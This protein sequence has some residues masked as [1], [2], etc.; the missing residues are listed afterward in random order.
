MNVKKQGGSGLEPH[1]SKKNVSKQKLESSFLKYFEDKWDNLFLFHNGFMLNFAADKSVQDY[2]AN[3]KDKK[4]IAQA[5]YN[6]DT[7]QSGDNSNKS[8]FVEEFKKTFKESKNFEIY[9]HS[10]YNREGETNK[11]SFAM[12]PTTTAKTLRSTGNY[13]PKKDLVVKLEPLKKT[14]IELR[15][16]EQIFLENEFNVIDFSKANID[17]KFFAETSIKNLFDNTADP[18]K[19]SQNQH[20]KAYNNLDFAKTYKEIT[21]NLS[22][23]I[24][25]EETYVEKYVTEKGSSWWP[26]SE[27]KK[28][29]IK[30]KKIVFNKDTS[31]NFFSK[32]IGFSVKTLTVDDMLQVPSNFVSPENSIRGTFHS[33]KEAEAEGYT[34]LREKFIYSRG[35]AYLYTK[36]TYKRMSL[37]GENSKNIENSL[38][39]MCYFSPFTVTDETSLKKIYSSRSLLEVRRDPDNIENSLLSKTDLEMEILTSVSVLSKE[40]LKEKT[41][42]YTHRLGLFEPRTTSSDSIE[43]INK[44]I[45]KVEKINKSLNAAKS[46]M[47]YLADVEVKDNILYITL[48]FILLDSFEDIVVNNKNFKNAHLFVPRICLETIND[49][50]GMLEI[51]SELSSRTPI[52]RSLAISEM[53]EGPKKNSLK[54][55]FA[56]IP[57]INKENNPQQEEKPEKKPSY[58]YDNTL[59][60][61]NFDEGDEV[62]S[63]NDAIIAYRCNYVY[64][65]NVDDIF[66]R[67][68]IRNPKALRSIAKLYGNKYFF[69]D[70]KHF[71]YD[72]EEKTVIGQDSILSKFPL[73]IPDYSMI[74]LGLNTVRNIP[75]NVE[76]T[77]TLKPLETGNSYQNKVDNSLTNPPEK[78]LKVSKE[79]P[80]YNQ[81]NPETVAPYSGIENIQA[82][83]AAVGA[84][85]KEGLISSYF[86]LN[87]ISKENPKGKRRD[88]GT[89]NV[90]YVFG[91]SPYA[92]RRGNIQPRLIKI[93]DE[94]FKLTKNKFP[95]LLHVEVMSGGTMPI[96]IWANIMEILSKNLTFAKR[97]SEN[98]RKRVAS[99]L[100]SMNI[101]VNANSDKTYTKD[102][103]T[104]IKRDR[105]GI[106]DTNHSLGFGCDVY[107]K[108]STASGT[109]YV[110]LYEPNDEKDFLIVR[111]FIDCCFKLGVSSAGAGM[112]YMHYPDIEKYRAKSKEIKYKKGLKQ[113]D[114][115]YILD[116]NNIPLRRPG[117]KRN[118]IHLDISQMNTYGQAITGADPNYFNK[119]ALYVQ[120]YNSIKSQFASNHF[121]NRKDDPNYFYLE[122]L[123]EKS[124]STLKGKIK[125]R[126]TP[127]SRKTVWGRDGKS[128]FADEWLLNLAGKKSTANEAHKVKEINSTN[129]AKIAL[130]QF[131]DMTKKHGKT[132]DYNY[133]QI[134]QIKA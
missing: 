93:L 15:N 33:D 127:T 98:E 8:S 78:V 95:E 111:Y 59:E 38:Y 6:I 25:K 27:D 134:S 62:F 71:F 101:F 90:K 99:L 87:N 76:T 104:L 110:C 88:T 102:I 22:K 40:K 23:T 55:I 7:K 19:I 103:T 96:D 35:N 63:E 70:S 49:R 31:R 64:K 68:E 53:E 69:T 75:S 84:M 28:V 119:I 92:Q 125:S 3:P 116:E 48:N 30:R 34:R 73:T 4:Y 39:T 17:N 10:I 105:G 18:K 54:A 130:D 129:S 120:N 77:R 2:L 26:W 58:M 126:T 1:L 124:A 45:A 11:F 20:L 5:T 51:D 108:R 21:I 132:E 100:E 79:E 32:T 83:N 82:V 114:G 131:K 43:Q 72:Y 12:K 97:K 13:T 107:L 74:D 57:S 133:V 115:K 42:D 113:Y 91:F 16:T 121:N 56:K 41:K 14:I 66:A 118:A 24:P 29:P 60:E 36:E 117:K 67:I 112:Y 106:H 46:S 86:E 47:D 123:K 44:R 85:E 61:S 50:E 81:V 65:I 94:A 9:V 89:K 128:R 122:E 52:W 37:K 109:K 80:N